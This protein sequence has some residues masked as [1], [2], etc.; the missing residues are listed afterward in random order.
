MHGGG[1][2]HRLVQL[3]LGGLL[4]NVPDGARSQCAPSKGRLLLHGQD[5][6]VRLGRLLAEGGDG[7]QARLARHVEIEH[8]HRRAMA[9]N[10]AARGLNI[11]GLGHN[12]KLR[13]AVEQHAQSGAH[14]R[15]VV[16]EHD[17]DRS[18]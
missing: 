16:G 11:A 1:A 4:E 5:H 12:L 14:N 13:V 17:R 9:P 6:Y 2:A 8:Q 15:M 10:V 3:L 7:L 18:C